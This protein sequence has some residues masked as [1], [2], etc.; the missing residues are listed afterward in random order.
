[1]NPDA[2]R[3]LI[4]QKDREQT[5]FTPQFIIDI[6]VAAFGRRIQYDPCHGHPGYVLTAKGRETKAKGVLTANMDLE[7][8]TG[9]AVP[10]ES[11]VN[12]VR[13]TDCLGLIAP[14]PDGTFVNPPFS[15]LHAWLEMSMMQSSD[16]I[17]LVPVRCHRKWWRKWADDAEV[18]PL[19][20]FAFVGHDQ[21]IPLPCCLARRHRSDIRSFGL[22]K[23]CVDA[24]IGGV[25]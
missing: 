7:V 9:R 13:Q 16:H 22:T 8:F 23:L 5:V 10:T 12:A 2:M 14:W 15:Q 3:S 18:V 1:M 17:M 24:G 6:V 4:G 21:S 11:C 19:N 20:P 25:W